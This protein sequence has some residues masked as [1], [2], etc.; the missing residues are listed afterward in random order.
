MNC[1]SAKNL[2][3]LAKFCRKILETCQNIWM[4]DMFDLCYFFLLQFIRLDV[5][6]KTDNLLL[7]LLH[8]FPTAVVAV[9][10]KYNH[11]FLSGLR[12]IYNCFVPKIPL[13]F[14]TN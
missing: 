11:N 13:N 1:K 10:Q 5:K 9:D 4:N 12:K 7:L 8:S 14:H 3:H 6:A 2:Q